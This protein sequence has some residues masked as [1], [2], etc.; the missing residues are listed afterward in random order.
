M[1]QVMDVEHIL[2]VT[3]SNLNTQNVRDRFDLE[4]CVCAFARVCV[5][6]CVCVDGWLSVSVWVGV[7][8]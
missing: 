5:C 4:V 8:G 3:K 7:G 1:W 6:V 2:N